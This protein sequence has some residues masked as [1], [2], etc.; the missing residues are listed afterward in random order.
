MNFSIPIGRIAGIPIRL[1]GFFVIIAF[2]WILPQAFTGGRIVAGP[3]IIFGFLFGSVV[4][5][6]LGHALVAR[7]FGAV[8]VDI[9]LWPLGGFTRMQR[10]PEQPKPEFLLAV[11]GPLV[12]LA[13]F[14]AAIGLGGHI[15]LPWS[16]SYFPAKPE[17]NPRELFP[18][19]E[20]P[21]DRLAWIN[22]VLGFS[23]LIPAFPMDGGRALRALLSARVGFLEAT[24]LAV[25]VARWLIFIGVLAGFFYTDSGWLYLMIGVFLW[26]SG[27]QELLSVQARYA[28]NPLQQ[29]FARMFGGGADAGESAQ[30]GLFR[31]PTRKPNHTSRSDDDDARD[32]SRDLENYRGTLEE[33]FK[34]REKRGGGS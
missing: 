7:R 20:S 1:H 11:A 26:W 15:H 29:M 24:K 16:D 8:I 34:E 6:E 4:L 23:N 5:H 30:G 12:N 19:E 33:Y 21:I 22:A 31:N 9:I 2:L 14:A 27:V 17:Y 13:I 3:F 10:M 28:Q 32:V 18:V 25:R